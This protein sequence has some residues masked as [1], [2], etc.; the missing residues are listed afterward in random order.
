MIQA[1]CTFLE[2]QLDPSNAL[3]IVS[4]AEQHHCNDLVK[5][6]NVFID[7][8]FIQVGILG[9]IRNFCSDWVN[10]FLVADRILTYIQVLFRCGILR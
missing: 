4:F 9:Y 1:C 7:Q 10:A 3:G 5:A 2:N 6:A 8:H